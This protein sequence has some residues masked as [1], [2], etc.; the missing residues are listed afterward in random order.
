MGDKRSPHRR[1]VAVAAWAT[2]VVAMAWTVPARAD[3]RQ[4]LGQP[5]TAVHVEIAGLP[6]T[7]PAVLELVETRTGHPLLMQHVRETLDHLVGLGRFED[8]RVYAHR[9]PGERAGVV[10]R[11][12]LVPL[13]RIVAIDVR[14]DAGIGPAEIR[15]QLDEAFG[16]TPSTTRLPA[17]VD[18]L[19]TLYAD[20]GYRGAQISSRLA[21]GETP[22]V[23]HVVFDIQ[24]GPR[25]RLTTLELRG[26]PPGD[27][28][29]DLR[30]ER[31]DLF[32]A[33]RVDD[34]LRAYETALR[35]RGYY[36]ASIEPTLTFSDDGLGAT[37]IVQVAAG[38]RVRVEFA[39]DPLPANRRETLVPI[40]AERSVDLDLL[41][42]ASRSIERYLREEGYREALAPY[43]RHESDGEVVITFTVTRG[44][45]HR[46]DAVEVTGQSQL[47]LADVQGLLRLERERPFVDA[48]VA[49]VAA[50]MTE[51]YHVRGFAQA[52]VTPR[53][54]VLP[55]ESSASTVYRPVRTVY[56]VV[57]GPAYTVGDVTLAGAAAVAE[58]RIRA[59]LVLTPGRPFYQ[60]QLG[61]DQL[62]I[63]RLYRNDGYQQVTV[64]LATEP[65]GS[66]RVDVRWTIHEGL[67]TRV[68]HVL[69]AGNERTSA[70]LIRREIVLAPGLPLGEDALVESQRRLSALGLFRR[71]RLRELPH[72]AGVNRDVVIEVEEADATTI[73][74]GGGLEAGRRLR[75]ADESGQAEERIDVAPRAFF[76]IGRRNLW[77]KNRALNLFTRISLRPR[78]P[79]A[80]STDTGGY[81]FNEY[82]VVG[83]FREP[84]AFGLTGAA[85]VTA[86]VEQAIR[87][88]F[89]FNR[90]G[91]RGE[92][93]QQFGER[94]T[95]S[96]RYAFDRT[97]LFDQRVRL[98]DQLLI[99]RLFPQV[100]LSTF[101]LSMLRD[102]RDDVLDP[103][104]GTVVGV[105]G[106]L[107]ARS[108]GSEV[109][110]TR[111]FLQ[112][113]IYRRLPGGS[114]FVVAA[115]A[116][117]GLAVGFERQVP[118]VDDDGRP[119]L[120]PD[121]QPLV[122]VVKDLP[123]SERFFAGGDTTVRGF[124]LDRLGTPETL[125]DFGFP[126]G[127]NALV[128]LN[129]ELRAPYWKGLGL[130][131]FL[132]AGNVFQRADD[133]RLPAL[134]PAAGFG[135]RYRSPLGPLR[136]D[137]GFN[138][139]RRALASGQRER[140]SVL[141]I[142]LGQ[143]F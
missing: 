83:T 20:R 104:R 129:L 4:Y 123:A 138:L 22:E 77:G 91:V 125:N 12:E 40:R 103:S 105:D 70:D 41:E 34:R 32:D 37:L 113:F 120:G 43:A 85:Q 38:P 124:V 121:G 27:Q 11:W 63:E 128:V 90:R 139:N 7:E 72:G 119:V 134:R 59:A 51:L 31:G 122:E 108:L 115:S 79:G 60:A 126:T 2:L 99:D 64:A 54:T 88:S 26:V 66:A 92:Y 46:V 28:A 94:V 71:V 56:E 135:I 89:N 137:L 15:T 57:E 17:M 16:A 74:Y 5:L 45:L 53:I 69:I 95:G 97:R 80:D 93:A 110:F 107:A 49:A 75:P 87:P 67:Q 19:R 39:G 84:R 133:I 25:A 18:L 73:S 65:A 48:Q 136:V 3:V 100:R 8:I 82:R 114:R 102:S 1:P 130:V 21:P 30:L 24:A 55:A 23:V 112:N 117:L 42:D 10:L 9:E 44:P 62:A 127:G 68:D 81:G 96:A 35:E 131:G 6:V 98:E 78:D 111:T 47:G 142:S 14:G 58:D 140:W 106:S 141:H 109:G 116:R 61:N 29:A 143:A 33:I 13:Q 132:D 86:F 76:E 36:E 101:T 52:A 118:R 50:A